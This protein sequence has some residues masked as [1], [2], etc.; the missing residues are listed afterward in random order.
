MSL[1]PS[2]GHWLAGSHAYRTLKFPPQSLD[3]EPGSQ[4]QKP[5]TSLLSTASYFLLLLH[6]WVLS[7]PRPLPFCCKRML[8][9]FELDPGSSCLSC[10]PNT[11]V[12]HTAFI[13]Q[14]LKSPH[15]VPSGMSVSMA[16]RCQHR[17]QV[18]PSSAAGPSPVTGTGSPAWT[19]TQILTA[20]C[21]YP[22]QRY[23][24]TQ[25]RDILAQR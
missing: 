22:P 11:W 4:S 20:V 10:L 25:Q 16:G 5:L 2:R 13:Q 1:P 6:F 8:W 24:E 3:R 17:E 18:T 19:G 15:I 9:L 21:L 12:R 23:L 7:P 14:P